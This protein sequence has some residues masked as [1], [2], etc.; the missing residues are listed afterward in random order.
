MWINWGIEIIVFSCTCGHSPEGLGREKI[1]L[2]EPRFTLSWGEWSRAS[3]AELNLKSAR[4]R[5]CSIAPIRTVPL[6]AIDADLTCRIAPIWTRAQ[7]LI[8][9]RKV[10]P[11]KI[12]SED[13]VS[14]WRTV[15]DC[16]HR[17]SECSF[18][19]VRTIN[20]KC[21]F[22]E[23][24]CE[25]QIESTL[26]TMYIGW[27]RRVVTSTPAEAPSPKSIQLCFKKKKKGI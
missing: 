5:K 6:P 11:M 10:L 26:Q 2:C 16:H 4:C 23:W 9:G 15:Q 19:S 8:I 27:G 14:F 3:L 17:S 21:I 25:F 7:E 18:Y 13:N 1:A 12:N 24:I 22:V 20:N